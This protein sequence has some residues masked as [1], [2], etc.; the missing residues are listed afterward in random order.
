[1]LKI[2]LLLCPG[3]VYNT[4]CYLKRKFYHY[5]FVKTIHGY[6][7]SFQC[8]AQPKGTKQFYGT[9]TREQE[10]NNIDQETL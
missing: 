4:T 1:M 3:R 5:S 7:N 10:S 8:N 6:L 2:A 9:M